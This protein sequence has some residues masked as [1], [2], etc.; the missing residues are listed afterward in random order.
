VGDSHGLSYAGL[1]VEIDG[2]AY[3]TKTELVIGGKAWHLATD[4]R[5]RYKQR[6]EW[7]V[8]RAPEHSLILCSWI[9]PFHRATGGNLDDIV[10][11]QTASYVAYVR[12]HLLVRRQTPLFFGVPAPFLDHPDY[13]REGATL[14]DQRLLVGIIRLFNEGLNQ[15]AS[16]GG[17]GFIDLYALTND[18]DGKASGS[19]HN[20][21]IHLRPEALALALRR[22]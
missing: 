17:F 12:E 2:R 19:L 21:S 8:A 6:F 18:R 15:A 5:N 3:L 10:R 11:R 22:R 1:D 13:E 4:A 14:E 7:A 9:L 16:A 20:D